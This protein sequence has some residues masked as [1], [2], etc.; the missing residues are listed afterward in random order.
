[1]NT[2]G[3]CAHGTAGGC[4]GGPVHET[5]LTRFVGPLPGSAVALVVLGILFLG[6]LLEGPTLEWMG[7]I[8]AVPLV[9]AALAPPLAT[10]LVGLAATLAAV[11]LGYLQ[12]DADGLEL[13]LDPGQQ[14]RLALIALATIGAVLIA[15]SRE[16]RVRALV[17]MSSVAEAAQGAIMRP[18]PDMVGGLHCTTLYQSAT[19]SARIGGDLIE[20]VATPFGTRVLIGDVQGKGMDAVRMAGVVLGAFREIAHTEPVLSGLAMALNRSVERDARPEEFVTVAMLQ[21]QPDGDLQVVSCG[22]PA[23]IVVR[24]DGSARELDADP[25]PPLGML[26]EPPHSTFHTVDKRQRIVLVTDGLLEARRPKRWWMRGPFSHRGGE[27]FPALERVG[28]TLSEGPAID[29]LTRL[30]EQVDEWT[31]GRH[32]DDMAMLVLELAYRPV[33]PSRSRTQAIS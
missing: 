16:H 26:F 15:Y 22:H 33:R 13:A 4:Q 30:R 23:P 25:A 21:M 27:F 24:P 9:A 31:D 28:Q 10:A 32:G 6:E 2:C 14:V 19:S 7:A 1:V 11:S 29:G 18:I 5:S 20:V 8:V 17:S 12:V 3:R